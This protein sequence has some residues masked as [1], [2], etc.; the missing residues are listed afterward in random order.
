M[1]VADSLDS[2]IAELHA[3]ST[4]AVSRLISMC[5]SSE[6]LASQITQRLLPVLASKRSHVV[7]VTGAP[8]V[9]K[10][11]LIDKLVEEERERERSVA[12]LAVD[13]SSFFTGG[14]VLGDRSRMNRQSVDPFVYIRSFGTSGDLGGL[15]RPVLDAIKILRA[16]GK[17]MIIVETTGVG[18]NEVE[19]ASFVHTTVVVTMPSLGD[20][21]QL[22]EAGVPE[23]GD[24]FVLNKA[25]LSGAEVSHS[26][27]REMVRLNFEGKRWQPPII[28]TIGTK[29]EGVV[30][31]AD[32]IDDHFRFLLA[33]GLVA[34][35]ERK[36]LR[37]EVY[38]LLK[39][40]LVSLAKEKVY[41]G[42]VK[43]IVADGGNPYVIARLILESLSCGAQE[44]HGTQ[45]K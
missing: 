30:Q 18:Q 16:F 19:V 25:D 5:E 26:E 24:V 15:S 8:G 42:S 23:I 2:L 36:A 38:Q 35:K 4:R 20:E 34:E 31:L 32:R 21:L 9:G 10:S 7:G 17:D 43:G 40:S 29:G 3:G 33:S 12:V 44:V 37:E 13:P 1:S 45:T 6:E 41:E 39:A 14:A 28:E 22:L 11:T 27:L